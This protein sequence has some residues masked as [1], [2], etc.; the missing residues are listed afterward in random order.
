M[1]R[2]C[3]WSLRGSYEIGRYARAKGEKRG[4]R[5]T[6]RGRQGSVRR[7]GLFY[8]KN[9]ERALNGLTSSALDFLRPLWL[10]CRRT[11]MDSG[12]PDRKQLQESRAEMVGDC[13]IG[14]MERSRWVG[15]KYK[16]EI[17]RMW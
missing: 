2:P 11:R 3:G 14:V 8:P 1:Q 5:Q 13:T 4:T 9:K 17:D 15:D 7:P 6:W 16:K 12:S 10:Q